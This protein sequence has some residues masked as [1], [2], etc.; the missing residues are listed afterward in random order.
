[1]YLMRAPLMSLFTSDPIIAGLG[2]ETVMWMSMTLALSGGT[3]LV[4]SIYQSIGNGKRASAVH[5]KFVL[6]FF[7]KA[8]YTL[9]NSVNYRGEG[10]WLSHS[11]RR[12]L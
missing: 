6:D 2:E 10:T 4:Y 9:V 5:E 8:V 11:L 3:M 7:G 1:M 12:S